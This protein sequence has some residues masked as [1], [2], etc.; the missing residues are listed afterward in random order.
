M[1]A[2]EKQIGGGHYKN[3]SIQPMEYALANDLNY[4]QANAIKYISRYKYKNGLE[5]LKKAIHCIELLVEYEM[6]EQAKC[7]CPPSLPNYGRVD[8]IG[9]NGNDGDHYDEILRGP[10]K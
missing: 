5:D 3:M 4:A 9:Q 10:D 6:K 7:L 1:S 2:S 8:I